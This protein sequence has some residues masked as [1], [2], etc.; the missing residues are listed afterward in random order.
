MFTSPAVH[1]A[2][3]KLACAGPDRAA[4]VADMQRAGLTT[5][6]EPFPVR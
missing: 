3:R 5:T 2:G 4:T 1:R 6:P